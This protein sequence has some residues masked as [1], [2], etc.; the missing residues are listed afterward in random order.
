MH[1][2]YGAPMLILVSS[3]TERPALGNTEFSNAAMVIHNMGLAATELEVG[4]CYIWGAVAMMTPELIGQLNL[5]EG[6][7]PCS[8]IILGQTE[9][10]F[11]LREIANNRI[12]TA[13]LK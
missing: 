13:Y 3:A 11:P 5:P 2:L 12:A 6:F 9:E 8:G 10:S 1:P 7:T 4:S